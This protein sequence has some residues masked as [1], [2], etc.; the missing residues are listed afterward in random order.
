L[1]ADLARRLALD[2]LRAV[3]TSGAYANLKLGRLSR[4]R[5]LNARDAAFATELVS[6]TLRMRGA[7][8]AVIDALVNR[9]LDPG[10]RDVLRLGSHQIL[11]MRVPVHAAV[12]T[13]V[14]L[15]KTALGHRPS[16]LV[17][18]VLRR[19]AARS[20]EEWMEVLEAPLHVRTSHPEWVVSQLRDALGGDEGELRELLAADNEPPK[21]TLVARP[22]LIEREE[23]PGEPSAVSPYGVVLESGAPGGLAAVREGRAGVQDAGSQLVALAATLPEVGAEDAWLDMCAGP[24]GKAALLQA[25]GD[26]RGVR[27]LANEATGHRAGLVRAAG[28]RRVVCGDGRQPAWTPGRFD[29]VLVDAPC[30]GLGALRRRPEARWRK[31]PGD[32]PEL[33]ALQGQLLRSAVDSVR[34]GGVVAYATCSPVVAETADVI[35]EL[36][37]QRPD[38]TLLDA[39]AQLPWLDAARSVKLPQALQLWPHRHGTDAMFLALLRVAG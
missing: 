36:L 12:A 24:G 11:S 33:V 39:A 23:L 16:G 7:Y 17:N 8:D 22:G 14:S 38:L 15:T 3:D 13:S 19:V 30:S 9:S 1:S 6:G 29:R 5:R 4:E 10:V 21:V 27:V 31:Q 18:A 25:L 20:L 2:V 32:L 34:P 28:V 37:A 35:G 26:Q